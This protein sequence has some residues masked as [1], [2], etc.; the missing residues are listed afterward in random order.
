MATSNKSDDGVLRAVA[1]FDVIEVPADAPL[2]PPAEGSKG[3]DT[4]FGKDP[5]AMRRFKEGRGPGLMDVE[6]HSPAHWR[7]DAPELQDPADAAA[8]EIKRLENARD[9]LDKQ[10]KNAKDEHSKAQKAN[11]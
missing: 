2:P 4:P 6:R 10:I 7:Q 8:V 3:G 9:L 5:N 1:G 11:R